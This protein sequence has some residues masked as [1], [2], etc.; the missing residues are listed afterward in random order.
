MARWPKLPI[1]DPSSD[2]EILPLPF[3]SNFLNTCSRSTICAAA[4]FSDIER[5]K[6]EFVVVVA[7]V[8]VDV[9]EDGLLV[10]SVFLAYRERG[11]GRVLCS[12][13]AGDELVEMGFRLRNFKF[14]NNFY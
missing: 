12:M 1:T 4:L 5:D 13:V 8:V 2:N 7:V 6:N 3:T 9:R 14:F 10:E 11:V